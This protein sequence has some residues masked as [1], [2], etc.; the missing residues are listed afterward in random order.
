MRSSQ[1]GRSQRPPAPCVEEEATAL[2]HEIDGLSKMGDRPGVEGICQR[3][4]IDQYP[5]IASPHSALPASVTPA[6]L[7]AN[8]PGLGNFSSDDNSSGPRTPPPQLPEPVVR[9]ADS[10]G[11][12]MPHHHSKPDPSKPRSLFS[13]NPDHHWFHFPREGAQSGDRDEASREHDREHDRD[14]QRAPRESHHDHVSRGHAVDHADHSVQGSSL[15]RSNSA[16]TSHRSSQQAPSHSSSH[17]RPHHHHHHRHSVSLPSQESKASESSSTSRGRQPHVAPAPAPPAPTPP[18][19]T[20]RAA[21]PAQPRTRRPD[22]DTRTL[23]ERLEEKLRLRQELRELSSD[24]D[25]SSSRHRRSK[26]TKTKSAHSV[27]DEEKESSPRRRPPR[28]T[29]PER[30]EP[31]PR[32]ATSRGRATTVS[33]VAPPRL[34]SAMRDPSKSK[35]MSSDEAS[36]SKPRHTVK[37][38][39]NLP[40]RYSSTHPAPNEKALSPQR[41]PNMQGLC[42]G[43]CPRSFPVAGV[44]DWYTLDGLNHLDICPSCKDQMLHSRFSDL[45]MPASPKPAKQAVRCAFSNAWVRLAW[46]QMIKKQHDSLELLYQMTRPPPGVRPCPGRVIVEQSWHRVLHPETGSPLPNFHACTSCARN[47]RILMPSHRDTFHQTPEI[48][49]AICDFFTTS[50]RFVAYID[51]LDNAAQRTEPSRRPDLREF[52]A[53]ARRKSVLKHCRRDRS[54]MSTWHY[55]SS[56][57]ELTACEDCYDEVIWPLAKA[58]HSI[59]MSFSTSMRLLPGDGHNRSREASCQLYSPRMRARFREAV[60]KD[61]FSGLKD[62]ALRRFEAERRYKDRREELDAAEKRGYDCDGEVRKAIE[63]WKRWE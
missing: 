11:L 23:A 44:N 61:D 30:Q 34:R 5:I 38:E 53:Y 46:T 28:P 49:P 27:Q 39:E 45:F 25:S 62:I 18:V 31:A 47:I 10:Q 48:E 13:R 32:P 50:P 57:T 60:A 51:L 16:R 37:F 2:A 4:T 35:A 26:S 15:A 52:I 22:S 56:L 33:A 1:V 59:A 12:A 36:S 20:P 24:S 9:V 7:S 8:P 63:E 14:T 3:G 55:M 43:S 58:H 40:H 21:P 41:A 17:H 6:C 42:T 29:S 54:T 19:P